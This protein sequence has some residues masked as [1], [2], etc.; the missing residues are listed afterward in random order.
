MKTYEFSP[1]PGGDRSQGWALLSVC[2]SFVAAAVVT[3]LLRIWVRVRLTRN[4]GW[5]DYTMMAAI[6]RVP[7]YQLYIYQLALA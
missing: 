4:L 5:D 1:P 7:Q 2:W 6:V 3:T